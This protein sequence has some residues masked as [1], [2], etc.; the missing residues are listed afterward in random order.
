MSSRK[1]SSEDEISGLWDVLSSRPVTA[2]SQAKL[3]RKLGHRHL[4]V[5]VDQ[6]GHRHI[7]IP[8]PSG[9]DQFRVWQSTGVVLDRRSF[10]SPDG[11]TESWLDL[12]C[13]REELLGVFAQLAIHVLGRVPEA[14]T[15]P[16]PECLTALEE[17]RDLL[18]PGQR[19]SLGV[20]DIAG[21]IGELLL[22]ER[23]AKLD[24]RGAI[25]CWEGPEGG[26]H[27]FRRER[28]AVEAK[29]SLRRAGRFIRINGLRQLEEPEGGVLHLSVVHLERVEGGAL[30]I[31]GIV[32]RLHGLGLDRRELRG[33][34]KK[35]GYDP[36]G[37]LAKTES[38]QL[39]AWN[40]YLVDNNFPRIVPSS[41]E[42]GRV[43]TGVIDAE[44]VIDLSGDLPKPLSEVRVDQAVRTLLGI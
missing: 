20:E 21:I 17:W 39:L 5:A 11:S 25:S 31:E 8:C 32:E 27:D 41:F 7:L 9:S 15:D 26:R 38:F 13:I 28:F 16:L 12:Y 3:R 35:V 36:S 2:L 33:K 1:S 19:Q 6:A 23:L 44:Y 14:A 34:L 4:G 18:G 24:A 37:T 43:P 10:E 29:A 40:T 30:S 42:L 22:L